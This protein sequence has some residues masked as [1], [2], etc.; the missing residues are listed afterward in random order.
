MS[1]VQESE[2]K[3]AITHICIGALH[4]MRVGRYVCHTYRRVRARLTRGKELILLGSSFREN[5]SVNTQKLIISH[6]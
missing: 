3:V 4:G 6:S 2:S 5:S 1:Y